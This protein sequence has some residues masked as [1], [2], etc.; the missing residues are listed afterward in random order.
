MSKE[1]GLCKSAIDAMRVKGAF[2]QPHRLGRHN[3]GW[4]VEEVK[5]WL[6]AHPVVSGTV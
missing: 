2:A 4:S 3:V 5:K 1:I 6:L